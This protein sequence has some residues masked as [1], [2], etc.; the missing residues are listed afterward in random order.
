VR[1]LL[2]ALLGCLVVAGLAPAAGSAAVNFQVKG[3]WTCNNNG[4][5]IPMSGVRVELWHEI[6]YWPDDRLGAAHTGADGSFTFSVRANSNFDLY[7]ELVLDDD[8][9]VYLE[10]WYS[11]WT[12][13]TSTDTVHSRS[14]VVDLGTWEISRSGGASGSPKC[15]I[16]QGA[17]NAYADYQRIVGS[18]PPQ[19]SYS[20]QADFPCCGTPFTT[21]TA[22]QWPA[23]YKT[24]TGSSDP[25]GGFSVNFHEF[26]H[27]VRH[28][29]DAA[30]PILSGGGFNHFLAD[31]YRFSY[32]QNHTLCKTTNEGFAFNEGWAEYWARTPGTCGDGSN[33]SQEGNVATA[34]TGLEKCADR[35]TM[36]RV[37]QN[38][39]N[40]IHSFAEFRDKFFALVGPKACVLASIGSVLEPLDTLSA[41]Q[42]TADV[43]RQIAAQRQLIKTLSKQMTRSKA[44]ARRPGGCSRARVC[45]PAIEKLI[46]PSALNAQIAGA[47]LV[48]ARL[49]SGLDAARKAQFMP[50]LTKQAFYT[51]FQADRKGFERANQA[52]VINGLA[53]SIKTLKSKSGF[54]A[55]RSTAEFRRLSS[56]LSRLMRAR[57]RK[58]STPSDVQSLFAPPSSPLDGVRRVKAT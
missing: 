55:A 53:Q 22:T 23:G 49:Q 31:A 6:S 39:P 46:E 13:N 42:L 47:K 8:K 28:T 21:L 10:N 4:V 15:A 38:N 51:T 43:L 29:F 17:H 58:A 30:F 3:K 52:I 2:I 50:D 44:R 54:G 41:D 37:L 57:K 26:A 7:A 48:L 45:L 56:R 14:G 32:P 40:A 25:D 19:G 35:P 16:W 11:P 20:I 1:R 9:G 27:A 18:R 24:G 36:V 5:R 12:W 34:L 33:F